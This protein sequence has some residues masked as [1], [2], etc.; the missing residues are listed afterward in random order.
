MALT[1][2]EAVAN[3]VP[4]FKPPESRNAATTLTV[5]AVLLGILFVGITYLADTSPS[6]PATDVTVVVR[7]GRHGLRGWIR[8][9]STSSRPSRPSSSS[10]PPTRPSTAFPRL[11]AILAEDFYFP[12]NFAYRGDRLAYTAGI[13]V[14]AA[15]AALLLIGFG[16]D[17]HA[18][19]PLYSVGVFMAFTLSQSGMVRHWLARTA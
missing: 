17:T 5:M 3:G 12:R 13:V 18:L 14:L 6:S 15:L 2:V 8:W 9:A 1:G 7:G 10:W 16:G 11:A 4:A 19:I